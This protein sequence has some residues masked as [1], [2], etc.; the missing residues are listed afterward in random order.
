[1]HPRPLHPSAALR[2]IAAILSAAAFS[3]SGGSP[4]APGG[5]DPGAQPGSDAG[6]PGDAGTSPSP[7]TLDGLTNGAVVAGPLSLAASVPAGTARVDFQVD[8]AVVATAGSAPFAATWDSFSVANGT[9][10]LAARAL[11][12]AGAATSSATL[13]VQVDNHIR[14]VFVIVFENTDWSSVKGN[15][16]APYINGTLLAQGAHA[17]KYMNVPGLHPSLPNYL[18]LEAGSNLGVSDDGEPSVHRLSTSQH[19]VSLLASAGVSWKSYQEDISG[20]DCPLTYV[21]QYA[22]KHNPMVYFSDVNGG[23]DA[24]S[25]ACIAHVRPYPELSR[26]LETDAVPAYSFLTPNLCNDMHDCGIGAGDAWLSREV[27]K[28]LASPAYKRGGALFVTFDESAG[29]DV[30]IGFIALSPLAKPGYSNQIYYTHSSTLR[31]VQ[32]IF[33]VTPMLGDAANA[34]DLRDLFRSF[35]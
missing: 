20:T 29:S 1:M 2:T 32:E 16:A 34:T 30:P 7:V 4:S 13:Q 9:H 27:P 12:G 18:W 11:D 22:P 24:R 8:G 21:S 10:A 15:A 3:C 28:I 33:G 23:L 25:S 17:E 26:D 5:T 14:N 6:S 19:L 35:P 31:T